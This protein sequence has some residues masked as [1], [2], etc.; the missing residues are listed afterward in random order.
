MIAYLAVMFAALYGIQHM[1]KE[2]FDG[3]PGEILMIVFIT[4]GIMVIV[5][6][7][8]P[9]LS[10]LIPAVCVSVIAAK[11]S[12]GRERDFNLMFPVWSFYTVFAVYILCMFLL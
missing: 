7:P 10:K 12:H 3:K 8:L 2:W 11:L 6:L 9:F 1:T 5:Y 4:T